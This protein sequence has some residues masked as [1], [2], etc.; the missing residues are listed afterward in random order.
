MIAATIIV[1]YGN[2]VTAAIRKAAEPIIGGNMLPPVEAAASTAA[3]VVGVY[4]ALLLTGI[5][6][7]PVVTVFAVG[8]PEIE[9][10]KALA[11]TATFADPPRD[12]PAMAMES[13]KKNSPAPAFFKKAP[14]S[15][16]I[17]TKVAATEI[18]EPHNPLKLKAKS[19]SNS[20]AV[21]GRCCHN[22]GKKCPHNT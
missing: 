1:A 16:K 9:P 10:N 6:K 19:S 15:I 22:P 14:K 20:P 21:N 5:V 2:W 13:L 3:A 7:E 4:P 17:K 18:G 11:I 12:L 8:L